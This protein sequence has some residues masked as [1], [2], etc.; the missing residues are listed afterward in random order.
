VTT[1]DALPAE[2]LPPPDFLWRQIS[3][4]Q[5]RKLADPGGSPV[6]LLAA[7]T[8]RPQDRLFLLVP[9]S[10]S[11]QHWL[12]KDA[13]WRRAFADRWGAEPLEVLKTLRGELIAWREHANMLWLVVTAEG[14]SIEPIQPRPR[15][16]S[17]GSS[18]HDQG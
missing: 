6:W 4:A 5:A 7:S 9:V 12:S 18:G 3:V 14:F 11:A 10:I 2:P 8:S 15:R 16:N 1:S 13:A 17:S